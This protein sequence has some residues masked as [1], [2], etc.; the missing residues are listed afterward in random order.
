MCVCV[1]RGYIPPPP[2]GQ[3]RK[4]QSQTYS[5]RHHASLELLGGGGV[6]LQWYPLHWNGEE[7][8][9]LKTSF[10]LWAHQG[11]I[12]EGPGLL[13]GVGAWGVALPFKE[14]AQLSAV[15]AST[16]TN[17]TAPLWVL[18]EHL[19]NRVDFPL[20]DSRSKT[21]QYLNEFQDSFA[22]KGENSLPIY[23]QAQIMCK[24]IFFWVVK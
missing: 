11:L 15:P 21:G 7:L 8:F 24:H 6:R 13:G 12:V 10:A 4:D 14:R 18:P 1:C 17:H 20:K 16:F 5:G 23:F 22:P 3:E 2:S 9:L 19:E